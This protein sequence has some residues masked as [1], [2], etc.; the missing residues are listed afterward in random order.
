MSEI[1]V[2]QSDVDQRG[3]K[4]E[5]IFKATNAENETIGTIY[6][7]P[8]FAYD[9]EPEHPHNL[10][11]SFQS[12]VG[13]EF[14]NSIK[15]KLLERALQ[16]ALEIKRET[17]QLKT[18]VYACFFAHQTDEITYFLNRG[19]IHDEGMYILERQNNTD[20]P[21]VEIP[22]GIVIRS[23]KMEAESEQQKFIAA[24]RKIFPR[25]PYTIRRLQELM[26]L[27]GWD[28]F[29]AFINGEIAG[30]TMVYIR[31]ESD[32]I[33]Y[34]EDMFVE[35]IWR[36]KGIAKRLL[37]ATLDYFQDH[38]I[39]RVQLEMWS[40]NKAAYSLYQSFA[41]KKIDETEIALGKYV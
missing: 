37:A 5:N 34:I 28:N 20:F 35:R 24:H 14:N 23:W 25:H 9:T 26:L 29:T 7:Y 10:F 18:R 13:K 38:G 4:R 33:G 8:F 32:P 21:S 2:V 3:A 27:P 19:F 6:I 17:K 36:R 41:F 31:N 30:N 22:R 39:N 12:E 16:R 11:L 15:D 1:I 40:A